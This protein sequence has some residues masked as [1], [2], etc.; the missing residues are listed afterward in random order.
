MGWFWKKKRKKLG[1]IL[2]EKGLASKEEID[3]ALKIQRELWETKQ[4]QKKIGAILYEKG[5]IGMEDVDQ[6]LAEQKRMEG[7]ILK[8]LIY[9]IFHSGQ[10]K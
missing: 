4:I 3:D 6:A 8:S 7:F 9:S 1:E 2:I 10:P 5:V